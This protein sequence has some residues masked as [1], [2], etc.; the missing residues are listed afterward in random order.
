MRHEAPKVRCEVPKVRWG[1]P[2][3]RCEARKVRCEATK[4][5]CERPAAEAMTV[6]MGVMRVVR[7][8]PLLA[9]FLPAFVA[10]LVVL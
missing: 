3:V 2:K 4:V 9:G 1:A 8:V 5:R 10:T 7:V 6:L